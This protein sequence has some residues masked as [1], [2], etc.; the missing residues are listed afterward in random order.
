[1]DLNY[2]YDEQWLVT[3]VANPDSRTS[4]GVN[5][6]KELAEWFS[7][8][9]AMLPIGSLT[10]HHLDSHDTFWWPS[11]GSKWRREQFGL[12]IT[13]AL[14]VIFGSLPGPFMMFVGGEEGIDDLIKKISLVKLAITDEQRQHK[15]WFGAE[16]PPV[17]F[18]L[19]YTTSRSQISILVNTSPNQI[20][21]VPE[22]KI[23]ADDTIIMSESASF[24]AG[25]IV[26]QGYGYLAVESQR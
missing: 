22:V 26:L 20:T 9:D 14:Y 16:T 19:T 15:W 6:G 10:A 8:R 12:Q 2:N 18:G 5:N 11:W 24:D 25:A 7:D 21:F 3:A 17:I 1:M 13:R 4:W 23:S